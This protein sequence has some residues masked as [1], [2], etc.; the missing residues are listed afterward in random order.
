MDGEP[1][2]VELNEI[3]PV[4][5]PRA[6]RLAEDT[7]DHS[8]IE[9]LIDW[10]AGHPRLTKGQLTEEFEFEFAKHVGS[11]FA[12]FVNSGSSANLLV[13]AA[14]KDSGELRNLKVVCPSVSWVTTV[15]P[16][17]QLGYEVILAEADSTNLGID[18]T[19]LEQLFITERPSLLVLVHV[20]GH[21][22]HMK[23]IRALC[24][25]YDVTIVED[26]CEALGTVSDDGIQAGA[27]GKA[28]TYSLYFG[29]H[30][31]TI[32]GGMIVTSD[33]VL[34]NL[35]KSMRSHGW[36]RDLDSGKKKSLKEE[37][38]ID[39]FRDLYTF[40][41]QGYNLRPTDL[42]ARIGLLQLPKIDEISMIRQKNFQDFHNALPGFWSQ[43]SNCSILSSFAYGTF[44]ENPGSLHKAL[45]ENNIES[46]PLVC[47]NIGRH[48]F[49]LKS[50][51]TFAAPIADLVHT[52]GIY[53]PNHAVLTQEDIL[54][55]A[56]IVNA[57]ATP[58]FPSET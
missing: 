14:L 55:I 50:Y 15:T 38:G 53:F 51:P 11:K 24:D 27:F 25:A 43:S 2:L 34:F 19:A 54:R 28:G 3:S 17:L 48:P 32:E 49:W 5:Q 36:A 56:D 23:A 21:L 13:A 47:G 45:A 57:E 39:D 42:Q 20:L 7:I 1:E 58:V 41:Y 18:I 22:N 30:I 44:V 9:Q 8:D 4:R 35:M 33:E 40:Y 26:S 10:L 37:F 52:K 46:R 31:S 12:V 6:I 16:F 29:H